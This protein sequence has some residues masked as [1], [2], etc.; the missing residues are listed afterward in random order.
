MARKRAHEHADERWLLT[1]ADMITLLMA[2]FMVMFSMAVVNKGKF[3]EL[4]RSLRESFAGPL[5]RGGTSILNVGTSNPTAQAKSEINSTPQP[6]QSTSDKL[7][8]ES[9]ARQLNA[10]QAVVQAKGLEAAQARDLAQA[11]AEVDAKIHELGLED[12]VSTQINSKGLVIRLVTDKVLFDLGSS[13]IR[14]AAFPLLSS[15]A[16]VVN[17]IGTNPI[18]VAGH[19]DAVPFRNDPH[20]NQRLSGD[21]AE[22]VLFFLEDHGFSVQR[23]LDTASEGFGSLQPLIKNDPQTG[24]GP[25]NRRVEVVVQRINYLKHAQSEAMG[26]LGSTPAGAVPTF[27]SVAPKITP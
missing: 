13:T 26:P 19:T 9:Q 18:R 25:R 12:K 3:D 14:P 2:L 16:R 24:S 1:Y 4:A 22:A 27:D 8:K 5:D 10:A 20:G 7:L 17:S 21:R 23:H 11:K 15:V 6:I